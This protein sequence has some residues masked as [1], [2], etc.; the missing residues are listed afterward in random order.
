MALLLNLGKALITKLDH[1]SHGHQKWVCKATE[2]HAGWKKSPGN[3]AP[4]QNAG[5]G[6]GGGGGRAHRV[7]R[8]PRAPYG[9]SAGCI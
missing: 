5:Q 4:C 8:P 3:A 7:L 9:W 6:I 2:S 1:M